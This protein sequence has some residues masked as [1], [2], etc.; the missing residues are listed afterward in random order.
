MLSAKPWKSWR[1]WD[2]FII[3]LLVTIALVLAEAVILSAASLVGLHS[4]SS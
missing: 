4:M 2:R 3:L 1:Q